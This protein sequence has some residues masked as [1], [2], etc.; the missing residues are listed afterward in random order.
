MHASHSLLSFLTRGLF[1]QWLVKEY[2]KDHQTDSEL[3]LCVLKLWQRRGVPFFF[4]FELQIVPFRNL[5]MKAPAKTFAQLSREELCL[6]YEE[7]PP[8]VQ[9][10]KPNLYG[11]QI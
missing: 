9:Q 8:N 7:N 4:F 6:N 3:H 5:Q 11:F 2:K 10:S 1:L